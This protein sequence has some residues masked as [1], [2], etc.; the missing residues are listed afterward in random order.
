MAEIKEIFIQN[1]ANDE[2]KLLKIGMNKT[3]KDLK[4]EIEKLFNL[5][6][7]L[8]EYSLR[9]VTNGMHGG[10]LIHEQD[11][12]KTLFENRFS[13]QCL[14]KFGKEKNRGGLLNIYFN[15]I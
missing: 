2:T 10:K 12:D 5:S 11:E 14:V 1:V 4:K 7:S 9:V 6:Y 8:D 15:L 3:V 13:T